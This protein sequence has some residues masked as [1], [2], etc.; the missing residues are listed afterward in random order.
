MMTSDGNDNPKWM[1][2]LDKIMENGV[3]KAIKYMSRSTRNI[4]KYIRKA[5]PVST[6]T[7]GF[8]CTMA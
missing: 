6:G 3:Q 4:K 5:A 2:W 8:S 1:F 7:M